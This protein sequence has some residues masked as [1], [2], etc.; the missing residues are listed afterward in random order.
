VALSFENVGKSFGARR[1]LN[2]FS[3]DIR[4]GEIVSVTGSNGAGKSTLLKIAAG[5]VRASRGT[6]TLSVDGKAAIDAD[7]RRRLIGYAGPDL[8]FYPELTGLENLSFFS[9]MRGKT[10]IQDLSKEYLSAVG[11]GERGGDP[12]SAYSSGMRQRLRLAF[13]VGAEAPILLL[14]E[15]SLALDLEG[16]ALVERIVREHR[17]RGG[18][19]LLATNDPREAALGDR[20]VALGK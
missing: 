10:G 2:N 14:D 8:T 3:L 12:V 13:A 5:L 15:P 18:A 17:E 11:L 20:I 4:A 7:S 16:V 1:V 19:T 6:T 9:T